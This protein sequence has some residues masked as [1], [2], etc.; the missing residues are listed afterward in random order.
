[1]K[2]NNSEKVFNQLRKK[3]DSAVV[4]EVKKSAIKAGELS[5]VRTGLNR[6]SIF[7]NNK[8]NKQVTKEKSATKSIFVLNYGAYY[9]RWLNKGHRTK[10]GRWIEGK[11]HHDKA[12]KDLL[13]KL[14]DL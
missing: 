14:K 6:K 9:D 11:E 2:D 5:P 8:T 13:D 7:E 12:I 4:E 1:M 10:N 3:I